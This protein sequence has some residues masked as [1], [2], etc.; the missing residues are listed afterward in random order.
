MQQRVVG[1]L[2]NKMHCFAC[3]MFGVQCGEKREENW[4]S[5]GVT[6]GNWKNGVCRFS[7]CQ[8]TEPQAAVGFIPGSQA[9]QPFCLLYPT[10]ED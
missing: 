10:F 1:I 2:N 7:N 8:H 4:I 9:D 6:G 3:R 5:V